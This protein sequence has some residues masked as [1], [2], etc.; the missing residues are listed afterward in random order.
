VPSK[1]SG[2]TFCQ[3]TLAA[4]GEKIPH[5]IEQLGR[6]NKIFFVHFR[7]VRGTAEN[8][9]ETFISTKQPTLYLLEMK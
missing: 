1:N 3:G 5:E 9:S 2:V 7:D 6:Q 8:F 4:A